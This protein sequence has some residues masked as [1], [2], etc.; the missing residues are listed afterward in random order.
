LAVQLT[1]KVLHLVRRCFCGSR[2]FPAAGPKHD[3]S[4]EPFAVPA[5][6][7]N[8]TCGVDPESPWKPYGTPEGSRSASSRQSCRRRSCRSSFSLLRSRATLAGARPSPVRRL[9]PAEVAAY[10]GARFPH[11][12]QLGSGQWRTTC[13]LHDGKWPNF[14]VDPSTAEWHGS[15]ASSSLPG[16]PAGFRSW[17]ARVGGGHLHSS[18]FEFGPDHARRGVLRQKSPFL[19]R[20][21]TEALADHGEAQ[22]GTQDLRALQAAR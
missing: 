15:T 16:Y 18:A 5:G 20:D 14:S 9:G 1:A 17:S 7:D 19:S 21:Y 2:Q 10:Y 11:L 6:A 3:S 13:P 12:R 8:T 4:F 22:P